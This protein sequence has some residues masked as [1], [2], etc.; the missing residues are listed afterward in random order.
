V[1]ESLTK[2]P[3]LINVAYA[4]IQVIIVFQITMV[5]QEKDRRRSRRI[6]EKIQ[7]LQDA[8]IGLALFTVTRSEPLLTGRKR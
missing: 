7:R 6:A 3:G 5:R 1:E 8:V 4:Q 2:P